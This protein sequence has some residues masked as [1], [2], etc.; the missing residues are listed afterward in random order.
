MQ[1]SVLI[2]YLI[3]EQAPYYKY[4][5]QR[6][7]NGIWCIPPDLDSKRVNIWLLLPEVIDSFLSIVVIQGRRQ[8][9]ETP[10]NNPITIYY[11]NKRPSWQKC[12]CNSLNLRTGVFFFHY[13]KQ[14]VRIIIL[15]H[16]IV[17]INTFLQ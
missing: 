12:L 9:G 3:I 4:C 15:K 16:I 11:S 17:E 8:R 13:F 14:L 5:L 7:E 10:H 6:L 2:L 1:L